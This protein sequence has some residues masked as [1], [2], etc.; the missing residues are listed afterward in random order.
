MKKTNFYEENKEYT[1]KPTTRFLF[2]GCL[3]WLLL[4]SCNGLMQAQANILGEQR[5]R[6]SPLGDPPTQDN[7]HLETGWEV[8]DNDIAYCHWTCGDDHAV[9]YYEPRTESWKVAMDRGPNQHWAF[10]DFS[11]ENGTA[12]AVDLA[13]GTYTLSGPL[14]DQGAFAGIGVPTCPLG[15]VE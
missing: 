12:G 1:L 14:E 2:L 6:C 10:S 13:A 3:A 8:G 4:A 7:L 9:F 5:E 15:A 11:P